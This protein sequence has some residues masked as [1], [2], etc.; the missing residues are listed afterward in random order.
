[1]PEIEQ[2]LI[3][4]AQQALGPI[5]TLDCLELDNL[6]AHRRLGQDARVQIHKILGCRLNNLGDRQQ[7][8]EQ[9]R[10]ARKYERALESRLKL[11]TLDEKIRSAVQQ[12][13]LALA[14]WA[15]G[16]E[17]GGFQ[18][19]LLEKSVTALDLATLLQEDEVGCQ[20]GV[21]REQ[22]GA[23][24]LWHSEEDYEITPNQ[25]FDKLRLFKFRAA[26]GR[27]TC[28]FIYPDLLP[29]PT[30]GWQAD[31]YAQAVDTLH[32]RPVD[33]EDAIL[34][35]A[36]AWLSLYLGPLVSRKE[37]AQKLGPFQGG[38]SLTA[39]YKIDDQILVEK[40]EYANTQISACELGTR[41]G[42]S[43]FQTNV[44]RD[45][46]LPIGVEEQTSPESRIWNEQRMQRTAR[47]INTIKNASQP[48]KMVLRMLE[49]RLGGEAAY[50]NRDVKA[51]L[52]LR[53]APGE[54][55]ILVGAGARTSDGN[56]FTA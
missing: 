32:V 21:L 42:E 27:S 51:Y 10:R 15:E 24:I 49:S 54:T 3:Q 43:L 44:I 4:Q 18:H 8:S 41:P 6:D 1:M 13:L 33:F 34:P 16:A 19:A 53:M 55:S 40:V 31:D 50:A 17:L 28:G 2:R 25:R 22:G 48:H 37:L 9:I 14:G 5:T 39:V 12:Y 30:F 11:T 7:V 20:T 29:G 46:S 26:G 38:Y 47:F 56:V 23:V 36:L 45:L 52:V 35:N